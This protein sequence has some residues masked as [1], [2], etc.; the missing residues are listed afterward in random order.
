[1]SLVVSSARATK[2]VTPPSSPSSPLGLSPPD[3][4][5]SSHGCGGNPASVSSNKTREGNDLSTNFELLAAAASRPPLPVAKRKGK[6]RKVSSWK[7]GD[8]DISAITESSSNFGAVI[9]KVNDEKDSSSCTSK[10]PRNPT[11]KRHNKS[12]V[13]GGGNEGFAID[14][15]RSADEQAARQEMMYNKRE[16]KMRK[17]KKT[18]AKREGHVSNNVSRETIDSKASAIQ[19]DLRND[20]IVDQKCPTNND[21]DRESD[22]SRGS[23][24]SSM[25][26]ASR[27]KLKG[28]LSRRKNKNKEEQKGPTTD[29]A[30]ILS[31]ALKSTKR[32]EQ[33]Q[34]SQE[35]LSPSA[36]LSIQESKVDSSH[37]DSSKI[38]YTPT[39]SS[40]QYISDEI[41]SPVSPMT[42][43]A[44][45]EDKSSPSSIV[46]SSSAKPYLP[47]INLF[48][49]RD[50]TTKV[51]NLPWN[52]GQ[53]KGKYS[54]PVNDFLQPHGKGKL[55]VIAHSSRT[56]HGT[57][58]DGKLVSPLTVEKEP[59]THQDSYQERRRDE[60]L[61]STK[62]AANKNR[63]I[64]N[65]RI[66]KDAPTSE[67]NVPLVKVNKRSRKPKPKPESKPP[68]GY[69]IGD[70]CRSPQDMI[71]R[72]SRI[73]A[74][75]S[76]SLLKKWDGAFIKRSSGVW[77]YAVLIERAHQPVDIMKRRLKY[78]HWT[79]VW[80]VDPRYEM[81]D[82]M[83]FAID[84][85]GGT[86]IIPKD[87]WAKFVRRLHLNSVPNS[88]E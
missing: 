44:S 1:M 21:V 17:N 19:Q 4:R 52:K 23:N 86:K 80:E 5:R 49:E 50:F 9:Y 73:E 85:N 75:E 74:S 26:A 62:F 27:G 20:V 30:S 46:P 54:G 32:P 40:C 78:C 87:A 68:V 59:I 16:M 33:S 14:I 67:E 2:K 71:I 60:P 8:D 72:H 79:S 24:K 6:H 58:K 34:E 10:F 22:V 11:Y 70:A 61:T 28:Y 43:G 36:L 38:L 18:S 42:P 56:F 29:T 12:H 83:L 63:Q 13:G 64:P 77:T 53:L 7:L 51:T 66:P 84:S 41:F 76:A 65:H 48:P 81:Q 39:S 88:A 15:S 35:E 3:I 69:K 25:F 45:D 37:E 47:S 55:V 57:W 31:P 82:S